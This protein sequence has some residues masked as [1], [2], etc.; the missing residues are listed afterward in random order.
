MRP[1]T[2]ETVGSPVSG[3]VRFLGSSVLNGL[4]DMYVGGFQAQP[5]SHQWGISTSLQ[6]LLHFVVGL[7]LSLFQQACCR[8]SGSRWG[9]AC[10]AG[11]GMA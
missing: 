10:R 9:C 1:M 8:L 6:G 3:G 5:D 2:S 11:Q 4:L 7:V